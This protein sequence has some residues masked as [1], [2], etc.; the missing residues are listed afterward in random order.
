MM[1]FLLIVL[2][3]LFIGEVINNRIKNKTG[4]DEDQLLMKTRH[5]AEYELR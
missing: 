2:L 3:I 1:K 5:P 4:E